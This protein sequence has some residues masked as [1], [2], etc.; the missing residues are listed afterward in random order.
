VNHAQQQRAKSLWA[1]LGRMKLCQNY[2]KTTGL[3]AAT[4]AKQLLS[5]FA[6]ILLSDRRHGAG[7][8]AH[9]AVLNGT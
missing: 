8:D 1:A 6:E 9:D 2:S 5:R 7:L 3:T 4:P